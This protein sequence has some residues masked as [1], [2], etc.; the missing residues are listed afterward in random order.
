MHRAAVLRLLRAH[1]ARGLDP[2]EAEMTALVIRFVEEHPDCLV[3][4]CAP[5]HLTGSA[6]IVDPP[7][8]RALL[9]HHRKLNKWLQPG[10]HADGDPDL[11]AV[12]LR[13]AREE[14]GLTRLAAV[15][16]EVF[17]VDRHWIPP[18]GDTPG[19]WHLDL[20]F[21]FQ[22]DPKEELVVSDESHDLKWVDL[23]RVA[24]LNPEESMLRMV[25]KTLAGR[26]DPPA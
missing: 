22:A 26:A 5:G 4:T 19:H 16:A 3:R 20:R 1:Q 10:G 6:W 9:V 18:R 21:L 12:A 17:D 25:R 11:P 7:R 13:E 23:A 8:G 24:A 14:T 15:T 2:A